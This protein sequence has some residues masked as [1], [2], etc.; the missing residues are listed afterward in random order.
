MTIRC[1][2]LALAVVAAAIAGCCNDRVWRC[3]D[4]QCSALSG[5]YDGCSDCT[6]GDTRAGFGQRI[7]CG[8]GCGEIY[9]DEWISDPPAPC[10]PCDE[11]T[12]DYIGR[13]C[14]PPPWRYRREAMLLGGRCAEDCCEAGCESC[15]Q[16]AFH[17][18]GAPAEMMMPSP[19]D[20]PGIDSPVPREAN[21][22]S[23]AVQK[24]SARRF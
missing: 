14:C 2:L 15:T 21:R 24:A 3:P 13:R 6:Q 10:D 5:R 1:S 18:Q 9:W 23:P 12:G 17:E 22:P 16:A 4:G 7:T 8:K 11:C 20:R 19:S